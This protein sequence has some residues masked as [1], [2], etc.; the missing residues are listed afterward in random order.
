MGE[1]LLEK[2]EDKSRGHSEAWID[3]EAYYHSNP[4]SNP[5]YLILKAN[6]DKREKL[7]YLRRLNQQ[8][9]YNSSETYGP[10]PDSSTS[11]FQH[12]SVDDTTSLST[13]PLLP[14]DIL[15]FHH[16]VDFKLPTSY[17]Q[18]FGDFTYPTEKQKG[19]I[20]ECLYEHWGRLKS[21][22]VK[23]A[24]DK[25]NEVFNAMV[26][27]MNCPLSK[28][29]KMT[30]YFQFDRAIGFKVFCMESLCPYNPITHLILPSDFKQQLFA[31]DETQVA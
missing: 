29:C 28:C 16:Q 15:T 24:Y 23:V 8:Q 7:R 12:T 20:T 31:F 6:K 9:L 26:M 17:F 14:K 21:N 5:I 27:G 3:E 30:V 11:I 1:K 19:L 18:V 22:K 4:A 2:I 25:D 10:L 13:K